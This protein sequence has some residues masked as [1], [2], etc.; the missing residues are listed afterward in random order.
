[1]FESLILNFMV[2]IVDIMFKLLNS[3]I[4]LLVKSHF[5]IVFSI[6]FINFYE[7]VKAR[8]LFKFKNTVTI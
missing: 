8:F 3:R 7:N 4:I 2:S 5:W 1:M 6:L